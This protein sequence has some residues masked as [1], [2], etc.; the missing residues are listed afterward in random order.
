MLYENF[1]EFNDKIDQIGSKVDHI[2]K[3]VDCADDK[4]V[5]NAEIIEQCN[6]SVSTLNRLCC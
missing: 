3:K 5:H 6:T 4:V 2:D 1:K